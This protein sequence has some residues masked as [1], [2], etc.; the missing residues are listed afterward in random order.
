MRI[1]AGLLVQLLCGCL[2][3]SACDHKAPATAPKWIPVRVETLGSLL[4]N[5]GVRYSASV[6]PKTRVE[7][8]FRVNGYID[9]I[10]QTK[11]SSGNLQPVPRGTRISKTMELAHIKDDEYRDKVKS[12]SANVAA[13]EAAL[14]KAKQDYRRAKDLYASESMTAPDYDSA[15]QEYSTAVANVDGARAQLDEAQQNLAYCTL[16]PPMDGVILSRNIELGALVNSSTVAFVLADMSVVKVVFAV[17]DVMLKNITLGDTLDVT[18][19]SQPGKVFSGKVSTVSPAADTSARVFEIE[20]TIP[21]PQDVLKDG[22]VA[23]LKVP[24]LPAHVSTALAVPISAVLRSKQDPQ[25]YALYVVETQNDKTVARLQDVQLGDVHGNRI[26]VLGGVSSG[27]QV[28][29]SGVTSVWD[30]GLERI[31]Q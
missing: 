16:V 17:P 24:E 13:A 22:M 28:I 9:A 27:Q 14:L 18:T 10:Y 25:G 7:L 3:L 8:K 11:D 26:A 29:V 15:Q 2:L 5:D 12:A 6:T 20:I 4:D 30:G 31:V 1:A 19:Q 23:A 21:N